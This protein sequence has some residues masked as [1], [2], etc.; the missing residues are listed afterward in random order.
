MATCP[1]PIDSETIRSLVMGDFQEP[2]G[3]TCFGIAFLLGTSLQAMG[4]RGNQVHSMINSTCSI[5]Q[6][7]GGV[8]FVG[9]EEKRMGGFGNLG[10]TEILVILG[11]CGLCLLPIVVGG[12]A[13]VVVLISR[14]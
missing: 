10:L 7:H 3:A 14:K 9:Q 5:W 2:Y 1:S 6:V 4:L 11:I 8:K 12:I 13:V